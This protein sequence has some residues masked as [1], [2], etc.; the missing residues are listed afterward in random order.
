MPDVPTVGETLKGVEFSSWLGL[1][2]APGTPRPIVDQLNKETRSI[3]ALD[4]TRERFAGFGGVPA[5]SSPEQMAARIE[6][7]IARWKR[8][9]QTRGIERQ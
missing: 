6:Q 9:V 1:A 7:E 4:E 2:V 3:L 8:V 5:P